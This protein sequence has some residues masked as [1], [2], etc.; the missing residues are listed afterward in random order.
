MPIRVDG[1][2]RLAQK[3]GTLERLNREFMIPTMEEAAHHVHS[4]VPPYPP[5]KRGSQPFVSERQ[6]RYVMAK[7]RSGEIPYRRTG[8]LGRSI[9]TE[10]RAIGSGV[11]GVI[12]TNTQY[13]PWVISDEETPNGLG[14]QARYHQDHWWTLQGVVR[15]ALPDVFSIF[16]DRLA[17]LLAK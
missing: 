2:D 9:T 6:R 17:E 7:I 8:L 1:L 16:E 15:D 14:P 13:S 5:P 3:L 12:G 11:Q 4:T 10:V